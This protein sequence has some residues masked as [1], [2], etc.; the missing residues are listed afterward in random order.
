MTH[1]LLTLTLTFCTMSSSCCSCF[2]NGS[3]TVDAYST[4][5]LQRVVY[6]SSFAFSSASYKTYFIMPRCCLARL[7]FDR[8]CSSNFILDCKM[9]P[10]YLVSSTIFLTEYWL[11]YSQPL[12]HLFFWLNTITEHLDTLNNIFHVLDHFSKASMLF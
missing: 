1:L 3:H 8:M 4:C 12:K 9:T 2:V 5:G 10:K 11:E 7:V 6:A